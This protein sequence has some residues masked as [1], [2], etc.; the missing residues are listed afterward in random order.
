[1]KPPGRLMVLLLVARECE[2][3]VHTQ[4]DLHLML[5]GN[6]LQACAACTSTRHLET[7]PLS[8]SK[9]YMDHSWDYSSQ[10]TVYQTFTQQHLY[11]STW[12]QC[13][14]CHLH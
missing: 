4:P 6:K 2:G 5:A 13:N 9:P 11:Y 1:M 8:L 14:I 7:P 12:C 10:L 3:T